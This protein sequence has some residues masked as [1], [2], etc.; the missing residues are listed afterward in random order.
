MEKI[1]FQHISKEYIDIKYPSPSVNYIT[2][3]F[4]KT[5]QK[6]N[7]ED[8]FQNTEFTVKKCMPFLDAMTS[9]YIYELPDDVYIDSTLSTKIEIRHNSVF[10]LVSTHSKEQLGELSV[11]YGYES[12]MPLKW[13]NPFII[14]TPKNYSML[15]VCP[16]NNYDLPF[17]TLGGVVDTDNYNHP[18]NFPFLIKKGF[19]GT[20]DKGTPIIQMIPFERKKWDSVFLNPKSNIEVETVLDQFYSEKH[21]YKKFWWTRKSYN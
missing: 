16:I 8:I 7:S 21:V 6:I 14:K 11:P 9:G 3:G 20:I 13:N 18:I 1:S 5:H 15:F 19:K 10:N 4:K 17:L 2:D 12:G